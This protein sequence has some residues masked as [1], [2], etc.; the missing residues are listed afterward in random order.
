VPAG[1]AW[2][3]SRFLMRKK[4]RR[5]CIRDYFSQSWL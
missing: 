5:Y 1:G 3:A 4:S 2:L